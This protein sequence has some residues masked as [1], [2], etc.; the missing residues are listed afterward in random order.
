MEA[1][2]P[3]H[4][5]PNQRSICE[6]SPCSHWSYDQHGEAAYV[7]TSVQGQVKKLKFWQQNKA[8]S[9]LVAARALSISPTSQSGW[10]DRQRSG[11]ANLSNPDFITDPSI[12]RDRYRKAGGGRPHKVLAYKSRATESYENSIRD[13]GIVTSD[14]LKTHYLTILEDPS[15]LYLTIFGRCRRRHNPELALEIFRKFSW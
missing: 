9:L 11:R 7:Q 2:G 1:V 4:L 6:P 5:F 15:L 8:C 12:F 10:R 3:R 14:T 13:S